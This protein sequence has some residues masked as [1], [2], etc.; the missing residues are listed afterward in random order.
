MILP[1]RILGLAVTLLGVFILGVAITRYVST[2]M[3]IDRGT[4]AW[5]AMVDVEMVKENGE[6]MYYPVFEFTDEAGVTH[7]QRTNW[8][9]TIPSQENGRTVAVIYLASDPTQAIVA[10]H[11]RLWGV[12]E[13]CAIFG[14]PIFVIGL[15]LI[16]VAP[17]AIR[18]FWPIES[19][20][21]AAE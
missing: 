7:R 12:A 16:F 9:S 20:L 19:F 17:R 6:K 13:A 10:E 8:G 21:P 3:F 4:K 1:I 15:L 18:R 14:T 2:K 5:G 11:W